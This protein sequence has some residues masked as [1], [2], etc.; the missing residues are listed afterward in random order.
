MGGMTLATPPAV[1]DLRFTLDGGRVGLDWHEVEAGIAQHLT[2]DPGSFADLVWLL[3]PPDAVDSLNRDLVLP[4]PQCDCHDEPMFWHRDSR[5]KRGGYWRCR[6]AKRIANA[7]YRKRG[8]RLTGEAEL[9]W[10]EN[11]RLFSGEIRKLFRG[12]ENQILFDLEATYR[13][14]LADGVLLQAGGDGISDALRQQIVAR[15]RDPDHGVPRNAL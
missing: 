5:R 2:Q 10:R 4:I 3:G 1:M 14:K 11:E 12:L 13:S 9:V 6:V 8:A 15:L 7:A